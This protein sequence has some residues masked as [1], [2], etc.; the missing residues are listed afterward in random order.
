MSLININLASQAKLT[1]LQGV[2][3]VLATRIV[4]WREHKSHFP[5]IES[6]MWVSGIGR[7]T[8]EQN[9]DRMTTEIV[10][11]CLSSRQTFSSPS[12]SIIE[13][14]T[15]TISLRL[16]TL[17]HQKR[18]L[19]QWE[20]QR[21]QARFEFKWIKKLTEMQVEVLSE[22]PPIPA[23]INAASIQVHLDEI[24]PIWQKEYRLGRLFNALAHFLE[25]SIRWLQPADLSWKQRLIQMYCVAMV[26]WAILNAS[27]S[28]SG[29]LFVKALLFPLEL[30]AGT[31][32][33][34][35]NIKN[36]LF[37]WGVMI[38]VQIGVYR[39]GLRAAVLI[40][41]VLLLH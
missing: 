22:V 25:L 1:Q 3:P 2:G 36:I 13:F 27:W 24:T 28:S 8:V 20:G 6:L 34:Y 26:T 21:E 23:D 15:I 31:F 9:R 41:I 17:S 19:M 11:Y 16:H 38:A 5:S 4:E 32:F 30:L 37:Y 18:L 10:A 14:E 12:S 33:T 39:A 7:Q 29:V 40:W 35:D